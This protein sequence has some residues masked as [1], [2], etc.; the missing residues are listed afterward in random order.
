MYIICMYILNITHSVVS[1]IS[2]DA[3][4]SLVDTSSPLE[5]ARV[6]MVTEE[7]STADTIITTL[8]SLLYILHSNDL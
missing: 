5:L 2:H 7:P 6:V 4:S 3:G 8:S 1:I